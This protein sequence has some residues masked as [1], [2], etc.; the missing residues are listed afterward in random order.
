MVPNVV[1]K[2]VMK[3]INPKYILI[4]IQ[5]MR[6]ITVYI[7]TRDIL[8]SIEMYWNPFDK[9]FCMQELPAIIAD[10]GSLNDIKLF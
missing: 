10:D 5:S 2:E 7:W 3:H 6:Q 9:F 1:S 4:N 8:K